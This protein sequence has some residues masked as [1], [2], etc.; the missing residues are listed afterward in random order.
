MTGY[1]I[2]KFLVIIR[3]FRILL[4]DSIIFAWLWTETAEFWMLKISVFF[5]MFLIPSNWSK[6]FRISCKKI[7]SKFDY[8]QNLLT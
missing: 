3:Y 6:I 4:S 1:F 2:A 8:R 5:L 7:G